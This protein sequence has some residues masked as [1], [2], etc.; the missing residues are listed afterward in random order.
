[1]LVWAAVGLGGAL[2]S[3]ARHGVNHLVFQAFPALRFPLATA[4]VNI[5]GSC[6]YG[7][8]AGLLAAGALPMR[9]YGREFVFVGV[10]GGVTTFSTF[11][12]ETFS[13]LRDG[14]AGEALLNIA[15]QLTAGI[16]GLYVG[17]A[18]AERFG[19]L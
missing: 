2:G 12:F 3:M 19:R 11:S 7:V 13:L 16:G 18:A 6:I 15:L 8:L 17:F 10:L 5:G 1:M 9:G 4:I 14:H